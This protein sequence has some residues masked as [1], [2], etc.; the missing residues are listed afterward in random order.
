MKASQRP[1]CPD[2]LDENWEAWGQEYAKRLNE[3]SIYR[4]NW[5]QYEGEK[6]NHRL[7]PLLC[8]MT[9]EHCAYCDWYPTD[10][11]TDRTIDHFSPK[12]TY[13]RE[14]YHWPNLS[15]A[16]E[17]A[18]R[19]T[20]KLLLTSCCARTKSVFRSNGFSSSIS[21]TASCSPIRRRRRLTSA[22]RLSQLHTS[23]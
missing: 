22:E 20:T 18:R 15:C 11:G 21:A 2:W 8:Q 6:V 4:F 13:P 14:A 16:V 9:D 3:E 5:K 12:A 1:E 23:S 7:M 17:S 19:K 10:V